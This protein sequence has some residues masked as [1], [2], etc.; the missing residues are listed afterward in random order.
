MLIFMAVMLAVGVAF[1][2][3]HQTTL[4]LASQL[5]EVN[6]KMDAYQKRVRMH[7]YI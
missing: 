3:M 7:V 6:T 5:R 4:Q 2:D 1:Y